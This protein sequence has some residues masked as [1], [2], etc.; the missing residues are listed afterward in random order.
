MW[1]KEKKPISQLSGISKWWRHQQ[2]KR[3]LKKL[4]V[5]LWKE[6]GIKIKV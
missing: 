4:A 2:N 1:K 3:K 5:K 6:Q